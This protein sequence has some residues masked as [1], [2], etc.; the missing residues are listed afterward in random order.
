MTINVFEI[1]LSGGHPNS[2]GNTLSVTEKILRNRNLWNDLLDCYQSPDE[3]VR[4]RVSS[5]LKRVCQSRPGWVHSDFQRLVN[6]VAVIDQASVKWTL[7]II[8]GLLRER[9]SDDETLAAVEIMKQNLR[10]PDWIVQNT[11]MRELM[12]FTIDDPHLE[13]WLRVELLALRKSSWKSVAGR[14]SKLL[15]EMDKRILSG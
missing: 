8:F 2:L 9:L 11:T 12:A 13:K 10:Y 15:A 1:E 4:L 7:S 6:E 14:A 3:V 5:C